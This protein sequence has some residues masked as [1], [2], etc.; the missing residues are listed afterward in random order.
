MFGRFFVISYVV[1]P[2]KRQLKQKIK[3]TKYLHEALQP[4]QIEEILNPGA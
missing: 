3:N 2:L 4:T 1:I